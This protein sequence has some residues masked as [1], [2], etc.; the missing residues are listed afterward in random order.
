V[1][2]FIDAVA[3]TGKTLVVASRE[4]RL[5]ITGESSTEEPGAYG[6][7]DVIHFGNLRGLNE[8]SDH[9]NVIIV[10]REQP[11]AQAFESQAMALWWD[12]DEPLSRIPAGSGNNKTYPWKPRGYRMKTGSPEG[13]STAYHPDTRVDSLLE[14]ARECEIAQAVDRL[15]LIR[16]KPG[17]TRRV[18]LLTSIPTDITVDYLWNWNHLQ[19]AMDI[20]ERLDGVVPLNA[21]DLMQVYPTLKS[22]PGAKV[23]AAQIKR[24]RLLIDIYISDCILLS[25][26]KTNPSESRTPRHALISSKHLDPQA[27]LETLLGRKLGFFEIAE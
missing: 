15:R 17:V 9:D 24:I 11:P 25:R 3:G 1:K 10:G 23:R 27:A 7:A 20:W 6:D 22:I 26:Y 2:R 16:E 19:R 12:E 18:F 8:F 14:Q 5:G 4:I 21:E 13:V